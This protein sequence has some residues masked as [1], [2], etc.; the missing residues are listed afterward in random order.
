MAAP[1]T[2]LRD[3]LRPGGAGGRSRRARRLRCPEANECPDT[4]ETRRDWRLTEAKATS[5][6]ATDDFRGLRTAQ[7]PRQTGHGLNIRAGAPPPARQSPALENER[8]MNCCAP[9]STPS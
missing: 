9:A 2:A 4:S 7:T 8:V 6:S 3:R 1:A 5:N